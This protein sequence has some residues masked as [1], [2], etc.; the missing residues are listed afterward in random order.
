[1]KTNMK[2]L[3]VGLI[4][5]G[6][7]MTASKSEA[8]FAL[9]TRSTATIVSSATPFNVTAVQLGSSTIQDATQAQ[10]LVLIDT[11]GIVPGA[12]NGTFVSCQSTF[13][14]S[15]RITV[16]L[17]FHSSMTAAVFGGTNGSLDRLIVFPGPGITVIGRLVVCQVGGPTGAGGQVTIYTEPV[18]N[19]NVRPW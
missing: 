3:F 8:A 11:D 19:R 9:S 13:A 5:L 12:G 1:M 2:S 10:F 16:P 4:A 17:M 6:C 7:L 15:Q 18:N 14:V